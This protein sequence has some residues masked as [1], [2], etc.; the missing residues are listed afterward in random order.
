MGISLLF[1]FQLSN[2]HEVNSK[3]FMFLR[4]LVVTVQWVEKLSMGT[5]R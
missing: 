5:E 2:L 1:V 4:N 3:T